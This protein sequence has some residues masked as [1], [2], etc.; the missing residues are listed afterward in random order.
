MNETTE[1]EATEVDSTESES[2][3]SVEN[4][5]GLILGLF[6]LAGVG[7]IALGQMATE[8][9]IAERRAEDLQR[10]LSQVIPDKNHDNNLLDDRFTLQVADAEMSGF[11]GRL[12]GEVSAV[13]FTVTATDGYAG[14]MEILLGIDKKGRVLGVRVLSHTETPGLGDKI[15]IAKS[16]WVTDFNGKGLDNL[17]KKEW[18]VKKDGGRF[19]AFSGATITPR[20]VVNAVHR[21]LQIF[22]KQRDEF[23]AISHAVKKDTPQ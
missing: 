9:S 19:D 10:S 3:F 18:A 15:E 12:A 2:A 16:D 23:L 1:T 6:T 14:P 11:K 13:A 21:A 7:L 17:S 20:A 4:W 8:E 5:P 22:E